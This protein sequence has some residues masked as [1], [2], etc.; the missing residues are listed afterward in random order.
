MCSG[1]LLVFDIILPR[2]VISRPMPD[3]ANIPG[4]TVRTVFW[5][6]AISTNLPILF[7]ISGA[8]HK[9]VFNLV[10]YSLLILCTFVALAK[11]AKATCNI[12]FNCFIQHYLSRQE[13]IS[14]LAVDHKPA[15]I[16]PSFSHSTFSRSLC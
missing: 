10:Y 6:T 16:F 3:L 4:C 15:E 9:R 13:G 11:T 14:L 5:L 8:C 2:L 7:M 12:T 1:L